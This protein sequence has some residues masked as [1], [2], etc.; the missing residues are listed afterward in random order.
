[1]LKSV[2]ALSAVAIAAAIASPAYACPKGTA[3]SVRHLDKSAVPCTGGDPVAGE[4]KTR[5]AA[6]AATTR[7]KQQLNRD[8]LSY[9][10][11]STAI[12]VGGDGAKLF[13]GTPWGKAIT[14]LPM[15]GAIYDI[16][17][18]HVKTYLDKRNKASFSS[19]VGKI[20][21]DYLTQNPA[22]Y[23]TGDDDL[24][25]FVAYL[26]DKLSWEQYGVV[27]KQVDAQLIA[28]VKS[29]HA[30]LGQLREE[31]RRTQPAPAQTPTV[32]TVVVVPSDDA[33][34]ELAKIRADFDSAITGAAGAT[35]RDIDI[36][37]AY[38]AAGAAERK[39]LAGQVAAIQSTVE[40]HSRQ[41]AANTVQI[42]Q[43]S[44]AIEGLQSDMTRFSLLQE[45]TATLA[46]ENSVRL[47]TVS[48]VLFD[49]V[50]PRSQLQLL[51]SGALGVSDAE[52][53]QL[54]KTVEANIA[55]QETAE[56]LNNFELGTQ[57]A[58]KALELGVK[59]GLSP[60]DAKR[61][62][63]LLAVAEVGI[64]IARVY[65][66][67]ISG[68]MGVFSGAS[69]LFGGG[70]P[71]PAQQAI[72]QQFAI[73]NAKLDALADQVEGV[74]QQIDALGKWSV[75]AHREVMQQLSV[76]EGLGKSSNDKLDYLISV[77]Q[78]TT[79]SQ[80]QVIG[81]SSYRD[82]LAAF[83]AAGDVAAIARLNE[84]DSAAADTMRCV[85]IFDDASNPY[86]LPYIH[87]HGADALVTAY[88]AILA[89]GFALG[90]DSRLA[91][92]ERCPSARLLDPT[93][94][95]YLGRTRLAIDPALYLWTASG[96][97]EP[98]FFTAAENKTLHNRAIAK[99]KAW[100]N[101]ADC[102]IAQQSLVHGGVLYGEPILNSLQS[103]LVGAGDPP[104]ARARFARDMIASDF[105]Y[106]RIN[107][108]T[109]IVHTEFRDSPVAWARLRE[110][111]NLCAAPG[112]DT[113]AP[114]KALNDLIRRQRFRVAALPKPYNQGCS[115]AVR[116]DGRA[117]GTAFSGL[118]NLAPA[119]LVAAGQPL[120]PEDVDALLGLKV[121]LASRRSEY[122]LSLVLAGDPDAEAYLASWMGPATEGGNRAA[123]D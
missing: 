122:E 43:N 23:S 15:A 94:I 78:T 48:A 120:Y 117:D 82:Y 104:A 51:R 105:S 123:S 93:A 59:A 116:V 102:A 118:L 84:L 25:G 9:E 8:L 62:S 1:M 80:C 92:I 17:T 90:S 99:L 30:E 10:V 69:S 13:K 107:L 52:R 24:S 119:A 114:L 6:D 101:M 76:L 66:G 26:G 111:E 121:E 16:T 91:G 100:E 67:D 73:V 64:G 55:K 60:E 89:K 37:R 47:D 44:A 56:L 110:L 57:I 58:G 70:G 14:S 18:A 86:S 46:A 74:S 45:Q 61:G 65:A 3:L 12:T 19:S 5:D 71:D 50:D 41:I 79:P 28:E 53:K 35:A 29:L 115:L 75:D 95:L 40:G 109:R 63:Q 113:A 36:L 72:A 54:E 106:L 77:A 98:G 49:N 68:L 83:A 112:S 11:K 87:H 108:A 81:G 39:E 38:V 88:P 2:T 31:M 34:A 103:A 97:K 85:R 96:I 22:A 33:K 27:G 21:G 7:L 42:Q 32:T 4:T 20:Y